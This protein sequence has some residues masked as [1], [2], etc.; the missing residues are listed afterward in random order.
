MHTGC[1]NGVSTGRQHIPAADVPGICIVWQRC[2]VPG[3][4]LVSA[5]TKQTDAESL[6]I[7]WADSPGR[8]TDAE[9]EDHF[10]APG[11]EGVDL[12]KPSAMSAIVAT[13]KDTLM[14]QQLGYVYVS[15]SKIA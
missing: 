5:T 3:N 4:G 7:I 15:G 14:L 6:A 10:L 8:K 1:D 9:P 13:C 2:I 12:S 11:I